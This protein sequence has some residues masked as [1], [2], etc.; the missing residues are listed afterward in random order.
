MKENVRKERLQLTLPLT[1]CKVNMYQCIYASTFSHILPCLKRKRTSHPWRDMA[2][3]TSLREM[4]EFHWRHHNM[5][6]KWNHDST[7]AFPCS[8]QVWT[9]NCCHVFIL[10]LG[11]STNPSLILP[12]QPRCHQKK[13]YRFN[14]IITKACFICL[15]FWHILIFVSEEAMCEVTLRVDLTLIELIWMD[16]NK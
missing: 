13:S 8:S 14:F 1:R 11:A 6:R 2:H 12:D 16:R 3:A 10:P 15:F 5:N 7:Y 9:R 4:N